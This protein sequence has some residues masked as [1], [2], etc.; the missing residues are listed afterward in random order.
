M[1]LGWKQNTD[2]L[3]STEPLFYKEQP[4]FGFDIGYGSLKVIQVGNNHKKSTVTGY[5]SIFYDGASAIRDGE[6]IDYEIVAKAAKE[7]F[8]NRLVGSIDTRRVAVSL[9]VTHTFNR[10]INLPQMDKEDLMEAIKLEADQYIPVAVDDL[11]IDY[12]IVGQLEGSQDIMLAAVPKRVVNSYINLFNILD[13]EPVILEPSILSVT[14]LVSH[15]ENADIPT[16]IIDLGS[17]TTDLIIY[18]GTVRVTGTIKFGGE[19]LTEAIGKA[20]NVDNKQ[21]TIIKTKYGIEASKKQKEIL[22]A[23]DP[24]MNKLIAEI[25]KVIRYFEDRGDKKDPQK[26]EQIII[27]GGGA[28][29]PGFSGLLTDELRVPTR[30]ASSWNNI[31]FGNLQP[32]HSIETTMY[33]TATGLALLKPIEALS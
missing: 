29:L 31:S 23:V 8:Q 12:Q 10:V 11:Y 16:L 7:L 15:S 19:T 33:A 26:V 2:Q 1:T 13:L 9:P 28:N 18:S 22:Q 27:L 21:A 25:K 17:M 24:S 20:L 30:L 3:K 5:G 14:R 32:P 6:I 4:C